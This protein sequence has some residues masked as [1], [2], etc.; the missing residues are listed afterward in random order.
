MKSVPKINPPHIPELPK[1]SAA[2]FPQVREGAVPLLG[3]GVPVDADTA[4]H[5]VSESSALAFG[6][7]DRDLVAGLMKGTGFLQ[8]ARVERDGLV[9]NYDENLFFHWE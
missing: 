4:D 9:L 1:Q 6:T 8:Y 7:Q 2:V 5:L 3:H